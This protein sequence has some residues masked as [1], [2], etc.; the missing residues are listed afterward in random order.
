MNDYEI[1]GRNAD[2]SQISPIV[3]ASV[4]VG[5]QK[6]GLIKFKRRIREGSSLR[7]IYT[8]LENNGVERETSSTRICLFPMFEC[9]NLFHDNA[10]LGHSSTAQFHC[11]AHVKR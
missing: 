2:P 10:N 7:L 4:R 11:Y 3:V 6:S 8:Q 9:L 5:D 1:D